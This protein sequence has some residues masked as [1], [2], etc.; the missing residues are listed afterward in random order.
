MEDQRCRRR[1]ENPRR[2]GLPFFSSSHLV[3]TPVWVVNTFIFLDRAVDWLLGIMHLSNNHLVL[4]FR[5][6]RVGV[7][8]CYGLCIKPWRIQ[9]LEFGYK[10]E[11]SSVGSLSRPWWSHELSHGW[12]RHRACNVSQ[13]IL[14]EHGKIRLTKTKSEIWIYVA[15]HT[16]HIECTMRDQVISW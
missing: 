13:D 9:D 10:R 5:N 14:I 16:K 12:P 3:G 6:N 4:H 1:G 2:L 7:K 8:P 11:E 15:Q